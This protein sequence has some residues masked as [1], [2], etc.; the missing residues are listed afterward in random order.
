MSFEMTVHFIRLIE[1]YD[2]HLYRTVTQSH[3]FKKTY[4]F[5]FTRKSKSKYKENSLYRPVVRTAH[6]YAVQE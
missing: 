5:R 1:H 2:L 3:S 4:M 6:D